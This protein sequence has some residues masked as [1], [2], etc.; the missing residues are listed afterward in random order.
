MGGHVV[1]P[2]HGMQ[3][4]RFAFLHEPVKNTFHVGPNVG[5]G[6]LVNSEGGG[7]M[8]DEKVQQ[9]GFRQRRQLPRDFTRNEMKAVA[10]RRQPYFNLF[11]HNL[12]Y[13]SLNK[14]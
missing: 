8:L 3:I 5:I 4:I 1:V 9:T 12:N 13:L 6:I 7:G 2:L 10:T 14:T 11:P